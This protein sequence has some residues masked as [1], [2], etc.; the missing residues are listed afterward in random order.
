MDY[1]RLKILVFEKL[2]VA[3]LSKT[4]EGGTDCQCVLFL[5]HI[6]NVC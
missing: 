3:N 1:Y 2:V 6:Y 5:K 4:I